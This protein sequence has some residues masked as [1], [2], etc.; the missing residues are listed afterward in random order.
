M[1][2]LNSRNH[3]T[4]SPP[5]PDPRHLLVGQVHLGLGAFHRAHQAVYT[6]DAMRHTGA[7]EWGIAAF[8]Q[9]S[10]TAAARLA[11]QDGLYTV[12]ERGIGAAPPRT[13]GVLKEVHDGSADP[14]ALVNRICDPEVHVVTMTVTEKGYRHDPVTRTLRYDD[15][16][17][18]A[19]LIGR[20]PRTIPAVLAHAIARRAIDGAHP[21][22]V[23]SCDNLPHNGALLKG[24]VR[25]FADAAN[26]TAALDALDAPGMVSFPS[27]VV[28]RIVPATTHHDIDEL[29]VVL[30]RRDN[31]PVICEPF[32]QWVIED[33][34]A[35]PTP[36]WSAVGAL[37]VD[38][39]A[40]WEQLKLRM[41]N[42]AH[43]TLAYLGLR[44]GYRSIADAVRDPELAAVCNRLFTEDVAPAISTP[45]GTDVVAYGQAVL[46]RFSNRALPHT[47]TQVAAD[48]SQKIG[49]RLLSTISACAA[50]GTVARWAILG[51]A[52]WALHVIK[53]IDEHGKP[54]E[55][56][57]HRADELRSVASGASL[58]EAVGRLMSDPTIVGTDLAQDTA[59]VALVVDYSVA[60]D[61]YGLE[62]VRAE[63]RN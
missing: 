49:P 10:G 21:L 33:R 63:L 41:L 50:R 44:F 62:A 43:S 20:P 23:L 6:E 2:N 24:L 17:V 54:V 35:G 32:S 48:G 9:R 46:T 26:L 19:D 39:A 4:T 29:A 31:A 53:P 8:T 25:Q 52:G 14:V 12:I 55:L 36:A 34:F 22:T 60:L 37:I 5:A 58:A 11:Q 27:S 15:P 42:A 28:D 1:N 3:G 30:G 13:V 40:P 7:P 16:E 51:V 38:D 18:H 45:A 61:R 57:D 56:A 59:F 47:T